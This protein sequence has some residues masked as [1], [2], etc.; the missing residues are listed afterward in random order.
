MLLT[1]DLIAA[2]D[3]AAPASTLGPAQPMTTASIFSD[4][5]NDQILADEKQGLFLVLVGFI[6]SFAFI[7]MSTR[8]MRSPR[9]PGGRAAWSA[10]A[11]STCTTWSSGSSR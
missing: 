3:G 8:L 6:L 4:F 10:T 9:C 7:R 5:W 1:L 11:A 2:R